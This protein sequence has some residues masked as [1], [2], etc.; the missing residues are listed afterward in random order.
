MDIID[1]LNEKGVEYKTSNNPNEI[2]V[3]CTS[4]IHEDKT[5]S[6]QY[7]LEKNMFH[8]WS[9]DFKGGSRK[10]LASLGIKVKVDVE[11][12]Q[13][14]KVQQLKNKLLEIK[15][16]KELHIPEDAVAAVGR[17]SGISSEIITGFDA[18]FTHRYDM[19]DY[20]CFPIYQYGKLRFFEGKIKYKNSP[21]AKY[22]RQPQ[23]VNTKD[24]LF[25]LD[26]I[27][28]K[29]HL[30]LVEGLFDML[31][32][33][34]MGYTNTV[35]IFGVSNFGKKK[36]DLLDSINCTRITV[37]FDGDLAG[38]SGAQKI[39]DLL[40]SRSLETDIV[41]LPEGRDPGDLTKE[42]ADKFLY[43]SLSK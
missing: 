42:E 13:P 41:Y 1:L 7:N 30:I 28:N 24:I 10:F 3:R 18:F 23:G 15:D 34:Q 12:K 14:Y 40:E 11:S 32:M 35:C 29:S 16:Q 4:G 31:N 5:P 2:L 6:M 17:M 36:A 21:K 22:T 26:K 25:P 9:C 43:S 20:V 19:D 39:K 33:W 38:R 27:K 37:L 8:C